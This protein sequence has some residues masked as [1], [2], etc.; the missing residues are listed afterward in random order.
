MVAGVLVTLEL[1][2][3][4]C[5]KPEQKGNRQIRVS[6]GMSRSAFWKPSVMEAGAI[7]TTAALGASVV[8]ELVVHVKVDDIVGVGGV[9][10]ASDDTR[11]PLFWSIDRAQES[12]K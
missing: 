12:V 10:G 8:L 7:L 6:Q 11:G 9:A 3:V 1:H 5:S 2:L 4:N